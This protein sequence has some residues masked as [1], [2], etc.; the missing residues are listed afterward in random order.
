MEGWIGHAMLKAYWENVVH[1][2]KEKYSGNFQDKD[3]PSLDVPQSSQMDHVR[4]T[5]NT[6][7]KNR[8]EDKYSVAPAINVVTK[9]N[10]SRSEAH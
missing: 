3:A 5:P 4:P 6:L 1:S 10:I 7:N 8:V 9:F 2:K